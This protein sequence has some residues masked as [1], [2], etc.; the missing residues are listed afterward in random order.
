MTFY[1]NGYKVGSYDNLK[2][3]FYTVGI[4]LFNFAA[5]EIRIDQNSI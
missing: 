2:Q 1:K 3:I 5:V 4:S